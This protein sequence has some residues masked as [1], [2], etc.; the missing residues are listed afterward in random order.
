MR[1]FRLIHFFTFLSCSLHAQSNDTWV[2]FYNNDTTLVGY[3]DINGSVKIEPKFIDIATP[4]KFDKIIAA[5][6]QVE[7]E[8]KSYYITKNKK[9]VG[10]DSVYT[11]D[12]SPDCE[13]EGFIRFIDKNVEQVGMLNSN[14]EVV[15]PAKYNALSKVTNGIVVALKDAQKK[16]WDKDKHSDCN[17]FTWTGGKEV[18]IDTA[19]NLLVDNFKADKLFL[20]SHTISPTLKHDPLRETFT[21]TNGKYYAFIN[22]DKEFKSWLKLSLLNHFNRE[23]LINASHKNI[24]YW[25]EQEGWIIESNTDFINRNFELIKAKLSLLK[26]S[27]SDYNISGGTLNSVFH[28]TND[29]KDYYNNCGE[30][31]EWAHPVQVVII[32]YRTKTDFKQDHF[33]FLRTDHGYRL[34]SMS[35][36]VGEIE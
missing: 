24:T 4:K 18:L 34:V 25:K 35:I 27:S 16:Y 5:M 1:Y 17:H 32:N 13:N 3:K 23:S 30:A 12:N 20:F 11:F 22:L 33:E 8:Y 31:K 15:I 26:S 2:A 14:G 7:G 6:E 21:G 29:F 19:N 36:G 9:I 28:I 10:R